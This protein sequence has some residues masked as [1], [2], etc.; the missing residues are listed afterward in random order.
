MGLSLFVVLA[1]R[2]VSGQERESWARCF[3]SSAETLSLHIEDPWAIRKRVTEVTLSF[4]ARDRHGFVQELAPEDVH[5]TEDGRP[6]VRMWAFQNQRDLPL[7]LGLLIDTSGS[8][9]PHFRFEQESAIQFLRRMVRPH[10][11]LAFVMGFSDHMRHTTDFSDDIDSLAVAVNSLENRG[12]TA[13]FDAIQ[14]ASNKLAAVAD[15]Q[16]VA[17]ALIILSDG[18]DTSSRA[19][20]RQALDSAAKQ[21]VTLYTIDTRVER[22]SNLTLEGDA[23]LRRLAEQTGGRFFSH[24][25]ARGLA[26]AFASIEEEMRNRFTVSY[27]PPDPTDDGRFHR[28]HITAQRSGRKFRVYARKGYYARWAPF[29]E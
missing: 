8:V 10:L 14:Q 21:D 7:R 25:N 24:M 11:D 2:G 26:T 13:L 16:S 9:N 22:I 27:R 19:T 3:R 29:T 4:T 5:V 6:I 23:V 15:E 18:D 12:G 17:R 20:F 1:N 28:I